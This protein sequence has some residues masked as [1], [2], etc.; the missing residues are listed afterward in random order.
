MGL[1]GFFFSCRF[2]CF[3]FSCGRRFFGFLNFHAFSSATC[4]CAEFRV[5]RVGSACKGVTAF[6]AAP[7]THTYAFNADKA[8]LW[9]AV[10]LFEFSNYFNVAFSY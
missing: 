4:D 1:L 5:W 9:T 2:G 8:A 3:S 7:D 10:G 6:A